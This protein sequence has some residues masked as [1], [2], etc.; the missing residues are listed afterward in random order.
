MI[1]DLRLFSVVCGILV[2]INVGSIIIGIF[3]RV[4]DTGICVGIVA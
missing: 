1:I 4:V 2:I 3:V